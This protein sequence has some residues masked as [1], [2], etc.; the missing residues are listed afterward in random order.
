MKQSRTSLSSKQRCRS[1]RRR[2]LSIGQIAKVVKRSESTVHWHVRDI[3]L[4]EAQR[5]RLRDQWRVVMAKVNARRQ[6]QP[7]KPIDFRTPSWSKEL[8]RL[9][10]HLSFDGRIDR[11]GCYYYNRSYSQILHV[12]QR[13]Y[14]LLG[15]NAR[16]RLRE[17]GVWV[18]S[19]YN[20]AVAAWLSERE[21]ELLQVIAPRIQWQKEWLQAFFDDEGHIHINGGI[22]RVRASQ[23]SPGLLQTA[24]TFLESLGIQSRID[25]Q[26]GA[27]EITGR[28]NLLGFQ[29]HVN[30]SPGIRVNANRRNGLQDH[31]LEKRKLLERALGSYVASAL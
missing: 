22:R 3:R 12:K 27:V 23:K 24:R 4:T 29:R 14:Q 5:V 8:V 9:V 17:N 15:V 25:Q 20:V 7:L 6:G 1:L 10:A 30:F 31:S 18:L 21:H 16:M 26:A 11:Y 28:K 2:G 19:Y 13:L